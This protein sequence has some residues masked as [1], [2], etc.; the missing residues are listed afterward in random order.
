MNEIKVQ[1]L[2][3][4]I[5]ILI[6]LAALASIDEAVNDGNVVILPLNKYRLLLIDVIT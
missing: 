4:I 2:I 6:R 3:S 1:V 5:L